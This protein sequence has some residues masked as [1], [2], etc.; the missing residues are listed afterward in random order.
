MLP[1]RTWK[2]PG[3]GTSKTRSPTSTIYVHYLKFQVPR[4]PLPHLE[5]FDVQVTQSVIELD[6]AVDSRPATSTFLSRTGDLRPGR[7]EKGRSPPQRPR[8]TT[9]LLTSTSSTRSVEPPAPC[10]TC[11]NLPQPGLYPQANPHEDSLGKRL[12][13]NRTCS[14]SHDSSL[15]HE[16]AP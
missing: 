3:Y 6:D 16:V 5:H 1:S 11:T 14:V 8:P 4:P 15:C 12:S 7:L 10:R 2:I 9:S 13:P